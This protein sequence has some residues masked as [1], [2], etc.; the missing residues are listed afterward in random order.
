VTQTGNDVTLVYDEEGRTFTGTVSGV[1]YTL[2]G[3]FSD[4][5]GETETVDITF[6]L[7][8]E[9]SGSGTASQFWTDGNETCNGGSEFTFTKQAAGS[10]DGDNDEGD[11]DDG[12]GCFIATAAFGSPMERHVTILKNLRDTYLLQCALGRSFVTTY[13][14][15]SPPLAHFISKHE[16]LKVAV[17]ISLMPLVAVSYGTLLFGPV[18]ISVMVVVLLVLP[19]FLVSC[20]RRK[21]RSYRANN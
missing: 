10:G 17:R 16:T 9:T 18:V 3:S 20:Y 14:K 2:S 7:S 6:I 11:G 13:Y 12:G 4:D 5:P 15:Y 19:I 8:S 1:T 21:A